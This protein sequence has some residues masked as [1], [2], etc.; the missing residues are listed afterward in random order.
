MTMHSCE[1]PHWELS[2]DTALFSP[3]LYFELMLICSL[4]FP[5][6]CAAPDSRRC[7][8]RWRR[9]YATT[10]CHLPG[11]F[12]F[13]LSSHLIAP[14]LRF[15]QGIDWIIIP[16]DIRSAT[17]LVLWPNSVFL[18]EHA[19]NWSWWWRLRLS[20]FHHV[21]ITS[22]WSESVSRPF[23]VKTKWGKKRVSSLSLHREGCFWYLEIVFAL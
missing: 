18:N 15:S 21:S 17:R 11:F 12:P 1:I 5:C 20:S 9:F 4:P 14:E 6:I 8:V 23:L 13:L 16:N 7:I 10:A 22:K 2:C 3:R 19:Q